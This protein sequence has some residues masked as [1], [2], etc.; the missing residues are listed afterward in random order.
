MRMM[1][2]LLLRNEIAKLARRKITYF[3]VLAVVL[4]CLM[5]LGFT[6]GA[7][8]ENREVNG[9]GFVGLAVQACFTDVA[10]ILIAIFA[11]MLIAEEVGSGT[12]RMVLA[13]PLTRCEFFLAKTAV[14]VLYMVVLSLTAVGV[15]AVL[16]GWQYQ[17]SDVSDAM[18]VIYGRPQIVANLAIAFALSM[19]PLTALV[20]FGLFISAVTRTSGQAIGAAVGSLILIEAGKHLLDVAPY[21][22]TSYIDWP[23]LVVQE[24]AAGVDYAWLPEMWWLIWVSVVYCV[25]FL[26]SGAIVFVRRDLNG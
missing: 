6:R 4:V 1:I 5:I 8:G 16:G 20:T 21:I 10:V 13:S 12:I 7:A 14:G 23:W 26:V 11:A 15:A 19:L 2:P 3:G 25:V 9:W 24:M 18:G 22:F 17:F